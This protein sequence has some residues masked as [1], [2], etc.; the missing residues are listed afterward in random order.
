MI[1]AD[2]ILENVGVALVVCD[3]QMVV[4]HVNSACEN[5]L[6]VSRRYLV[7]RPL[8][9]TIVTEA[10]LQAMVRRSLNNDSRYTLREIELMDPL[11]VEVDITIT[12]M[13]VDGGQRFVTLELNRTDRINR[14][15]RENSNIE[16][17]KTNR[18][19]MRSLSHEIKNPLSGLRGAAQLLDAELSNQELKEF[20]GIIIKESD[21]LTNLV[22]RVMGS[23]RQYAQEPVNIHYVIE[24]VARLVAV[25]E[26]DDVTIK[27]DYD[28]SLPEFSGD[29][30]QMIQAVLN[31]VKNAIEAQS[32]QGDIT[33]GFRTRLERNF[34]IDKELHRNLIKLQIWDKGPGVPG[35]LKAILFNPM[36]TGRAE[37]TGLGLAIAQEIIQRH[38]G[39]INLE[40]YNDH[41]C[42]AVYLP[43]QLPRR[44]ERS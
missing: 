37:G 31:V 40:K 13:L 9:Q 36:I 10:N 6:G 8:T 22:N 12:P 34:T 21:R 20:T 30:E 23:H 17:Q 3:E 32:G 39:L 29:V 5:L 2:R 25:S 18:L 43:L 19:I 38:N 15:A 44:Q 27:R 16:Q 35:S 26:G 42:F 24:H 4:Q 41:T 28:P 7:R 11:D 1:T 14:L 33:V